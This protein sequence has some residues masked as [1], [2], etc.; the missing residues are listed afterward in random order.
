M[1]SMVEK[2][3]KSRAAAQDCCEPTESKL[4]GLCELLPIVAVDV[5]GSDTVTVIIGG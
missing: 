2:E 3:S 5:A 1:G 4:V